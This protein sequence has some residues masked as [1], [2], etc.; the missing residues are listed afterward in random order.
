MMK[1]TTLSLIAVLI[2]F[3]ATAAGG[4]N[5]TIRINGFKNETCFL[6]YY[7]G[8]K[9]YIRDSARCDENGKFVFKG[10]T[11]LEGGIYLLATHD[12]RL[13]FDFVVTEQEFTLDTDTA[14]YIGHMK[15][16]NSYENEVFFNYSKYTQ[17]VGKAAEAIRTRQKV[18]MDA[19]DTALTRKLRNDMHDEEVRVIDYRKNV[20]RDHPKSLMAKIF[21]MMTEVEVPDPPTLP[22][23]AVDSTFQYYYYRAHYFD[24][25]DFT[26]DRLVRTPVFHPKMENFITKVIT[27]IP[28][29]IIAWADTLITKTLKSKEISKYVIFWT[30]NY[31]ET[32]KYMGMDAV[33]SHLALK[34]YIDTNI[35][36]WVDPALRFKIVDRAQTLNYGLI[37]KIGQNLTMPDSA[38]KYQSLYNLAAEYTVLIFWN[39]TCGK[40]KEEM[41]K[42]HHL[43]D[44]LNSVRT[45][46]AIKK[47]DVYAV[48]LTEDPLEWKK[49]LREHKHPW[50]DVHDPKHESN[51]RKLY[52][53]YSTPV[54]YLLGRDKTIVAKRLSVEMILDFIGKGIQ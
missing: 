47:I 17:D 41:P 8:D 54:I 5:I 39:A 7:F 35:T 36:Y 44:S 50:T 25:F 51:F 9:Q 27:Q 24:H 26:D 49:Y 19:K 23:G 11:P 21:R 4:F 45:P 42:L 30:T 18:A 46:K 53:V 15:V 43:Y 33:F 48:S 6:G 28:D 38:G 40:C 10:K 31:Y 13:L 37:G 14:D 52:D 12:K 29:T 22:N 2:T 32:S 34:Y 20:I 16:K 1:R 3:A